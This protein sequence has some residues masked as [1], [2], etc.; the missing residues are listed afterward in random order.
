[1]AEE[2]ILKDHLNRQSSLSSIFKQE[3]KERKILFKETYV[4][5]EEGTLAVAVSK[6]DNYYEAILLSD[7]PEPVVLHWGVALQSRYDWR[8]PAESVQPAGSIVYDDK[9]VQTPFVFREGLN[10]LSL[11]FS[12]KG[13]PRGI[14]FVL[15]TASVNRW[16]KNGQRNFFIPVMFREEG[17]YPGLSPIAEEIIH[18][19]TGDHSWT[20]MHRFNLCHDLIESVKKNSEGL[21]MIYVWMRFSMIRQ[22]D[23]QRRYNTKPRELSHAQDRLT[24]K[25]AEIYRSE[26]EGR[27]VLRLIMST[28]GRG[29]EGQRIRDEILNIMH[30]HHIK[31]VAGHFMEEWHQKL[32]NNTTPD[33]IV[34]CEAYLKFLR[35]NGDL[36]LFY[37]TLE[38]GGVSRERMEGFERPITTA[39]DF[40]PHLKDAL[41]HDFKN[42]LKLLRSI[43][44]GTDLESAINA[45]RYLLDGESGD[46]IAFIWQHRDTGDVGIAD[47]I[48][49][50]THAR[51]ILKDR[52]NIERDHSRVRDMLFLDLALEGFIR[53][54]IERSIHEKLD[55]DHLVELTGMMLE[56]I[57]FS[58][59]NDELSE[60]NHEWKHLQGL[61][62]FSKDWSLHAKAV[63][64]RVSRAAG[65]YADHYYQL[66]QPNA[67]YL[68]R[69][70][71][72]DSWT[73]PLFTEEV[74]RGM[75][76]FVISLLIRHLEPLLRKHA[77]LGD[78]Q[79]ISP[80]QTAGW[81]EVA[82]SLGSVQGRRY[83]RPSI[84]VADKVRGDEEPPEGATAIITPDAVDLVSHVAVRARNAH[85][86]FATCY[87]ADCLNNLKALRDH[88]L[89][90]RINVSGDVEYE[91][92]EEVGAAPSL[93]E[94]EYEKRPLPE[95][96][97]YAVT[98][99]DFNERLTGGKSINLKRLESKLP[100]WIHLP[101]SAALPFCIFDKVLALDMN[102]EIAG[103]Y[104]ELLGRVERHP[105]ET[106]SEIRRTIVDLNAPDALISTLH[107]IMG[108]SGL[109]WHEKWDDIWM[110][111][112]RVWASKWNE[113]AYLS[114]NARRIQH[115]D[116]FM[117]VLIQQVVEA[118]YAF[119]IHTVNPFTQ[120]RNELYAE[121][122]PGL[123]E[124]LVG[125]YPGRAFSFVSKRDTFEAEIISYPSKST[126]LFGGGLIF[127]SDSNAEDLPEYAGAGLYD[128]IMLEPPREE[129]LDYTRDALLWNEDFK[130]EFLA[131]IT[132]IGI[133]VEDNF[134]F[135]QD[136]EG[137][138]SGG[139]YYIVQTRPQM[140]ISNS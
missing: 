64:E 4:L 57:R 98:S 109:G 33:D 60:S 20:L 83:D 110:C 134:G 37:K 111:I 136:I 25:I 116:I 104:N 10:H 101:V 44:S 14:S 122:V 70:F 56:N 103:R 117:A 138:Y 139:K 63:L 7:V 68:G 41:I 73:I 5:G 36:D 1:M 119:V 91:E 3:I 112:K 55:G 125:N 34:I 126:G 65:A 131:A 132:K 12:E 50:I 53:I 128:S 28:L 118:E 24:L 77:K 93:S 107:K 62:R 130:K 115:E 92:A 9:A 29:G 86:L 81:L 52:L 32:H 47:Y 22:L 18:G 15:K 94:F 80:G 75:P 17:G 84:I 49:R 16:F 66:F 58:Y 51:L 38:A 120:D 39:P 106:L 40:V 74:V 72:A 113:R 100:D 89:N 26:P 105:E 30:R 54:V 82:D 85:I 135:P 90:L 46:I 121:I 6:D 48:E 102:S 88:M 129:T 21:A 45:A 59:D 23:W 43:H 140:G 133:L 123:G 35:S 76:V 96:S 13:A 19:E 108:D 87:D 127:R 71:S 67:E 27:G 69:A 31:E 137:A 11:R 42:Y 114:R 78:W 8:L 95:F 61:P 2:I 124:T 99:G 97:A 79:V